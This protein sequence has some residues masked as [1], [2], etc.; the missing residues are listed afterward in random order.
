MNDK[1][2][3]SSS[4]HAF[5]LASVEG[6]L[7]QPPPLLQQ[8]DSSWGV[9]EGLQFSGQLSV[10]SRVGDPPYPRGCCCPCMSQ[11]SCLQLVDGK[12][13]LQGASPLQQHISG[14]LEVPLQE[15]GVLL[16][17]SRLYQLV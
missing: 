6:V 9:Y 1:E 17:Q 3:Y 10:G 16:Q 11:A 8:R 7:G 4:L 12:D 14:L 15:V 2:P 13:G 5:Q